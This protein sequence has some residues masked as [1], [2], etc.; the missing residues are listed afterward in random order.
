MMLSKFDISFIPQKAIKGQAIAD[1]LANGPIDETLST[2][3]DFLDKQILYI[4]VQ[5]TKLPRWKMCFD[6]AINQKGNGV[7]AIL[8]SPTN[9]IIPISIRL[10]YP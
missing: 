2:N 4:E 7:G 6:G 5:M 1:F 3:L 9:V 8:I 10:C